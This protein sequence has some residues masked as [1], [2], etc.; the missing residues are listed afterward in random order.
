MEED[1]N[2]YLFRYAFEHGITCVWES[3][4]DHTPLFAVVNYK[5]IIVKRNWF[6]Q[7]ENFY[8]RTRNRICT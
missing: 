7:I 4:S 1:L 6:R 8:N 3:L 5:F 2:K